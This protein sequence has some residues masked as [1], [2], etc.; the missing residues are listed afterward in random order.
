MQ[1]VILEI[2]PDYIFHMAAQAINGVSFAS[3]IVTMEVNVMGTLNLLEAV[4]TSPIAQSVRILLAGSSTVYGLAA[5]EGA[6]PE[7]AP[8]KPVSPYGVSKASAEMLVND[9]YSQLYFMIPVTIMMIFKN[10]ENNY[11]KVF[12]SVSSYCNI[13]VA[14]LQS[15]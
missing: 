15:G 14:M 8:M 2:S 9:N 1:A 4:R 12:L 6:L 5:N 3:P 10:N 13:P 7:T 11:S